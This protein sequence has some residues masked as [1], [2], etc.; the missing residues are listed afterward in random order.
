[1]EEE[2]EETTCRGIGNDDGG[3]VGVT[4]EVLADED[5]SVESIPTTE[6]LQEE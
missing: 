5:G 2:E 3:G 1:M 6:E 4:T